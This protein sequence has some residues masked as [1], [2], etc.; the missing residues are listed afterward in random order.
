MSE[1]RHPQVVNLDEIAARDM[2]MSPRFSSMTKNLGQATGAV[3]IGCSYYE[4]APGKTAFPAHWHSALEEAIFV[5]EGE[6]T[7]R[8]GER[9][10]PVRA[11][12]WITHLT[13]PDHAHQLENTS[14]ETLRY[15]CFSTK[16]RVEVVG[17]P[18]SGKVGVSA[19]P[20]GASPPWHRALYLQS[21]QVGYLDGEKK[22]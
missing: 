10:V 3:G 22:E 8:L 16:E 21:S 19:G 20:G 15:L 12:D 14:P 11:G 17:Y 13:G 1:R 7:V 6:G 18:D 4:L 9:R 5:L 2:T